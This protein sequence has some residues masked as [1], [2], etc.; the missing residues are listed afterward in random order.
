LNHNF[1]YVSICTVVKNRAYTIRRCVESVLNQDYPNIE[2]VLQDGDSTDGT[3]EILQEYERQYPDRIRLVSLHDSCPEESFFRALRRCSG[4]II[5]SC[6]SDDEL[7]PYAASWAVENMARY[8]SSAA[9]YGGYHAKDIGGN[10]LGKD[11]HS[12]SFSIEAYLC[13][14]V[15]PPFCSSFFRRICLH[16]IGLMRE[17]WEKGVGEFELWT[18]L[19]MRYSIQDV[20]GIVAKIN[21]S[22][23]SNTCNP[24]II[25]GLVQ[26]R[27]QLMEKI[28]SDPFTPLQIRALKQRAYA[29]LHL[30]TALS[31]LNTS[32]KKHAWRQILRALHYKPE[33][34]YLTASLIRTFYKTMLPQDKFI[35]G[36]YQR[37]RSH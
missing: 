36:L 37:I 24:N 4:E 32:G 35:R 7:F 23:Y 14:K 3:L 25:L 18:R 16:E 5:G 11:I 21:V 6:W 34:T 19:G 2:Y 9:I 13:H 8:P 1:P 22:Q 28:F 17:D 30:W 31:L 12:P 33:F 20:P 29:G 27:K 10:I 26:P 15:I